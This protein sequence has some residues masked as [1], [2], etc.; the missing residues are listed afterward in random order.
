[1]ARVGYRHPTIALALLTRY[2]PRDASPVLDAGCGTG[3]LGDWLTIAGYGR[4]EGLDV[5][6]GMLAAAASR[7][8]Y[9]HLHRAALGTRLPF[10][11]GHFAAIVAAGV[12]TTGHVG[13]EGLDELLRVCRR[14]G[15]IVL[16]VKDALWQADFGRRIAA[17][18]ADRRVQRLEETTPYISMPGDPA[19]TTSRALAL[20]IVA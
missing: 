6:D 15:V 1:M 5:S 16:T 14:G 17:L 11:D 3:V 2:A 12:F 19:T 10:A 9:T 20:R 13:V 8:R 18:E 7:G 4:V